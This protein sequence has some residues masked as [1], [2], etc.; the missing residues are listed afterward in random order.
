M[1]LFVR[2][3]VLATVMVLGVGE[4]ADATV[5]LQPSAAA[6]GSVA[7]ITFHITNER[8]GV[9]I[10]KVQI[11]FPGAP[12]FT[13]AQ[14]AAPE[15]WTSSVD[16]SLGPVTSVT[17]DA[18]KTDAQGSVDFVL[19]STVPLAGD[20]ASFSVLQTFSDGQVE[21]LD[22]QTLG[23][24][25]GTATTTTALPTVTTLTP[26]DNRSSSGLKVPSTGGIFIA[27]GVAI[28]VAIVMRQRRLN[29]RKK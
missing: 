1:K 27:V 24:T 10:K 16:E 26:G 23:I 11:L 4:G 18:A 15:G 20:H 9:F 2:V 7:D 12:S 14:A 21:R 6:A 28:I 19:T 3:L 29:R 25:G 22:N 13:S 5:S 8:S 17:F